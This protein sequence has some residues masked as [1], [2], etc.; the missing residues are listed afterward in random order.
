MNRFFFRLLIVLFF[1]FIAGLVAYFSFRD[2]LLTTI[3]SEKVQDFNRNHEA[4]VQFNDLRFKGLA[5]IGFD[6]LL[7]KTSPNDSLV[8]IGSLDVK[9]KIGQLVVGRIG[10]RKM[11]LERVEIRFGFDKMGHYYQAFTQTPDT[12]ITHTTSSD[13]SE[14]NI[15][16]KVDGLLKR[17]FVTLPS[18]FM[19]KDVVMRCSFDT[20]EFTAYTESLSLR[21]GTIESIVR[22]TNHRQEQTALVEGK[23]NTGQRSV[24]LSVRAQE[25]QTLLHSSLAG[26]FGTEFNYQSLRLSFSERKKKGDQLW[27]EGNCVLGQFEINQKNLSSQKIT[28]PGCSMKF[29]IAFGKNFMQLDSIS[30]ITLGKLTVHPYL[31]YSPSPY[32]TVSFACTVSRFTVNDFYNSLPAELFPNLKNIEAEGSFTYHAKLN[33]DLK[34]PDSLRL[35][36][37]LE[38]SNFALKQVNSELVK[39]NGS[40]AYTAY[41]KGFPMR[42]FIVGSEN[43]N[44]LS[45]DQIPVLL[46]QAVLTAE[47]GSFYGHQGFSHC[48]HSARH[49]TKY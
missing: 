22:F 16:K 31:R 36:S 15:S 32:D 26:L 23:I 41:E 2:R 13:S 24:E 37:R 20:L 42:T 18:T 38:A 7:V 34:Q 39:M 25:E 49:G 12:T 44:F 8:F 29:D 27:L 14:M 33:V 19:A 9:L 40:F 6:S 35:E 45:L 11:E 30:V 47:D 17:I 43:D 28:F 21:N 1:V 4:S 46:Q 3:V 10:F 5:T 48:G